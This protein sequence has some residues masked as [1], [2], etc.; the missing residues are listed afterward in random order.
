MKKI[1]ALIITVTLICAL[2]IPAFASESGNTAKGRTADQTQDQTGSRAQDQS[3][4]QTEECA[5]EREQAKLQIRDRLQI[6]DQAQA[7][8]Q[9]RLQQQDQSQ[10][11]FN[12]T[13]T[14][15]ANQQIRTAYSWGLINGYQNGDFEPDGDI[16]GTEGV[17][18]VSRL[19][20]CL[21]ADSTTEALESDI[22][23]ELVPEWAREQLRE[24]SALRI[25]AQ[26]QCYGEAQLNRLQLAVMLAKAIGIEPAD[27]SD[28]T[29]V[30]SDQSDI[31]S[32]DLGYIQALKTLG[33][34]EGSDG[35]FYAAQ[36]VTRAESAAMLTRVLAILE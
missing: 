31:P 34:I 33:V 24:E 15:W 10:S 20:A 8:Y 2:A 30:F 23:W 17:L 12:D 28:D 36:A 1:I 21:N 4:D 29:V 14:H 25:A 26:S 6:R 5:A 11:C 9:A 32:E 27:V 3:R 18:M 7:Q 16:S 35:C 19:A 22:D 13:E